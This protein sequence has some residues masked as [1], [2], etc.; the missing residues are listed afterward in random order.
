M[1]GKPE[2]LQESRVGVYGE[3]GGSRL[4]VPGMVVRNGCLC[5][6]KSK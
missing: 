6:Q 3:K 5:Q 4:L 2:W 1:C